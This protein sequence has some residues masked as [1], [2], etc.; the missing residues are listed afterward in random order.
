MKIRDLIYELIQME[1]DDEARIYDVDTDK[2]Y[3]VEDIET[4]KGYLDFIIRSNEIE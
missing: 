2:L 1:M 3:V 4:D